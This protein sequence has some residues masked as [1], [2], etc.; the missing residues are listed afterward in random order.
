MPQTTALANQNKGTP[1]NGEFARGYASCGLG[2]TSLTV[3]KRDNKKNYHLKH[4]HCAYAL[5]HLPTGMKM[6]CPMATLY[7][8]HN[9][10][11]SSQ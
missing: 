7:C 10:G 3:K 1:F 2:A 8:P 4:R 11:I 9:N 5:Q 6:L